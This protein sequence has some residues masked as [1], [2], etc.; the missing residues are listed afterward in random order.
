MSDNRALR[1]FLA[2]FD[3]ALSDPATTEVVVNRPGEFGV[4]ARG[5]WTWHDAP[6]LDYTRLYAIGT[7]AAGMMGQD[8]GPDRPLCASTLPDGERIQVCVPP[9]VI[10]GTVSLTIRKPPRN[11]PSLAM[12]ADGGLFTATQGAHHAEHPADAEL[13]AMHAVNDWRRFFPLAVLARKNIVACGSTGS[14][15]TSILRAMVQAIP[16]HERILTIEDTPEFGTL[17]QRNAVSLYYSKGDQGSAR[18]RAEELIEASL[19]MRPDRILLQEA[20]DA[21]AFSFVRSIASGHS[22]GLTS[23]HADSPQG[24]F[25]V[26]RLLIKQH[27]AGKRIDDVDVRAMLVQHID[28]V[29]HCA[30]EPYRITQV[31]F[32]P[33]AKV[34]ATIPRAA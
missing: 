2:P 9:A 24:A 22:G 12:L 28:V 10:A 17:P 11:A 31:Y 1:M 5:E 13:Q 32:D 27:D 26:M 20:R 15:K 3:R 25:D 14:G 23:C 19:R 34:S 7:L 33:A 21:A 8:V 6:A 16:A 18:V 30:K 29:I 4:E